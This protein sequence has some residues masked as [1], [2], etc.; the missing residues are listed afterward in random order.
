MRARQ[1]TS[2]RLFYLLAA[3]LQLS[4]PGAASVADGLRAAHAIAGGAVA[5]VEEHTEPHCVP[6]HGDDCAF[7]RYL[8]SAAADVRPPAPPIP[9]VAGAILAPRLAASRAEQQSSRPTLPRAPP[10]V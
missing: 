3:L 4:L 9:L 5:H 10:A 7:C 8:T 2:V 1:R 6:V